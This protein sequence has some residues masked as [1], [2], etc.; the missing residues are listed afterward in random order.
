MFVLPQV[1][2]F[3]L[4]TPL[5]RTVVLYRCCMSDYV[6]QMALHGC[7]NIAHLNLEK[8]RSIT[9]VA[10]E[11]VPL[12]FLNMFGCRDVHRLQLDCPQLLAINLGQCPN[13]RLYMQGVEHDLATLYHHGLQ[14]VLPGETIRWSHDFPPQVY[15]C[16]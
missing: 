4:S 5:A 11:A 2:L 3:S 9:Q 6:L 10:L 15:V 16:N 1:N 14:I 12:K 13:V 8:C 7:P